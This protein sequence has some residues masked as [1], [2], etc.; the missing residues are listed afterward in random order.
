MEC[1]WDARKVQE[2]V[3]QQA[4]QSNTEM[5]ERLSTTGETDKKNQTKNDDS[6]RKITV[7]SYDMKGAAENAWR[8]YSELA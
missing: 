8:V 1:T 3:N 4:V 6:S 5:F 2:K 7:R